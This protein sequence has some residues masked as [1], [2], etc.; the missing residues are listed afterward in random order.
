M[1][2]MG[3]L[4]IA[5]R[6]AF[7]CPIRQSCRIVGGGNGGTSKAKANFPNKPVDQADIPLEILREQQQPAGLKRS[8]NP[9]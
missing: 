7:G 6:A 9:A 4:P 5:L 8:G 1:L 3:I 2:T